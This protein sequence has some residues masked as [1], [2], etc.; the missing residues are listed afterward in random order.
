MRLSAETCSLP[1]L[2]PS[3]LATISARNYLITGYVL[4]G[5]VTSTADVILGPVKAKSYLAY[6][7]EDTAKDR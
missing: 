7:N 4:M 1:G 6:P 5:G 3:S 2:I